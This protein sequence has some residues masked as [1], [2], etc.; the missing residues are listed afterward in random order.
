[1]GAH[2]HAKTKLQESLDV[3]RRLGQPAALQRPT[4]LG[5]LDADMAVELGVWP[6]G[7]SHRPGPGSAFPGLRRPLATWRRFGGSPNQETNLE[8]SMPMG[9]QS[10]HRWAPVRRPEAIAQVW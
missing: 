3:C 7:Y 9:Q 10:P 8:Q 5:R 1:M 2:E 4:F 6:L